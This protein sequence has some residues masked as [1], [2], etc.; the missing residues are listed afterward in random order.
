MDRARRLRHNFSQFRCQTLF[1]CIYLKIQV[2]T[3]YG[4]VERGDATVTPAWQVSGMA[5]SRDFS[6]EF[7]GV[8]QSCDFRSRRGGATFPL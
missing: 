8:T 4:L 6:I 1:L 2:L 3:G 5:A 7:V